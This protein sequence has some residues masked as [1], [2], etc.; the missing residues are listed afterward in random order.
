MRAVGLLSILLL[1]QP[2]MAA[3][4]RLRA[5]ATCSAAVVRLA[6]V[7]EIEAADAALAAALAEIPLCPAPAVGSEKSLTQQDVRQLL[8][9]SGLERGDVQVTGS[10]SVTVLVDATRVSAGR[11]RQVGAAG[12]RQALFVAPTSKR[13]G[14]SRPAAAPAAA[15]TPVPTPVKVV[16]RG[17]SVTAISRKPGICV[18]ETG[19]ATQAGAIGDSILIELAGGKA[20]ARIVA[21][22]TVE[23][24][25][26]GK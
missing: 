8:A 14:A 18:T 16:E 22:Q 25:S 2:L 4:V 15:I 21:P 17:S 6:D 19:K 10:E 5:S 20:Q 12:V 9:F 26:A 7:A 11:S 24:V 23:V 3:E 1:T 13:P